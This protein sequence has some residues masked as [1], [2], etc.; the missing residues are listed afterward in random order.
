MKGNWQELEFSAALS[1]V[2]TVNCKHTEVTG[3]EGTKEKDMK[4]K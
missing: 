4:E 1:A 2:L 3:N